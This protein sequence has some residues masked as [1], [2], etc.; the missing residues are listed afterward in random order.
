MK[1][2]PRAEKAIV[3]YLRSIGLE[4]AERRVMGGKRD[5]GDV[6][7]LPGVCIESKD[8][9][10]QTLAEWLDEAIAE[11]ENAPGLGR[12]LPLVWHKRRGKGSAADWY[13]T[14]DGRTAGLLLLAWLGVHQ[15]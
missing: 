12:D 13:V 11:A 14:T 4:A 7:G 2:G 5:R 3:E 15:K 6:A 1:K 9:Q 8:Q 10:R